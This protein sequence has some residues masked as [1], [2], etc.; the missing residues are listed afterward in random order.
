M[1]QLY[2]LVHIFKR[3]AYFTAAR[4][5]V[6]WFFCCSKFNELNGGMGILVLLPA[7]FLHLMCRKGSGPLHHME[8]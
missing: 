6:Q 5:A 2:D 8:V 7:R 4:V 3:P 1:G